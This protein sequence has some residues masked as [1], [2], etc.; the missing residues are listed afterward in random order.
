MNNTNDRQSE[1]AMINAALELLTS[2]PPKQSKP[3][4]SK[5]DS[6]KETSFNSV[7]PEAP[8][9]WRLEVSQAERYQVIQRL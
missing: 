9:D 4:E 7:A 3:T 5:N 1:S 8:L 2:T 6:K